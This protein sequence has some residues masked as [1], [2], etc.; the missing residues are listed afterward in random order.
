MLWRKSPLSNGKIQ[1]FSYALTAQTRVSSAISHNYVQTHILIG[2]VF[3]GNTAGP[4]SCAPGNIFSIPRLFLLIHP[5]KK[6]PRDSRNESC[7]KPQPHHPPG[8]SALE[9]ENE[10]RL[11]TLYRRVIPT[12]STSSLLH[13]PARRRAGAG[14][15]G[16]QIPSRK[17]AHLSFAQLS[18][19]HLDIPHI[20]LTRVHLCIVI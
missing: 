5:T 11:T 19:R 14:T 16:S 3:P 2:L 10:I 8:Q 18:P 7:S 15:A 6:K 1:L 4:S 20:F 12:P 9:C 13:F 17:I